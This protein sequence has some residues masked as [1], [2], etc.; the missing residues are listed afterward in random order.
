MIQNQ[1]NQD[2]QIDQKTK[3]KIESDPNLNI[4]LHLKQIGNWKLHEGSIGSGSYGVV[5]LA[6]N[7][8]AP[9]GLVA[10]KLLQKKFIIERKLESQLINEVSVL[11]QLSGHQNILQILDVIEDDKVIGIVTEYVD[12]GDLL[13]YIK[14]KKKTS[15]MSSKSSFSTN[16]FCC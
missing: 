8:N 7:L 11:K 16:T 5:R 15:R 12:G 14:S 9:Q 2:H 1:Q 6:E 3:S 13:H 4:S 10:I